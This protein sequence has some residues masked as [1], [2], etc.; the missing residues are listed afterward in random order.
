MTTFP[1]A[2]KLVKGG[3][4]LLDPESGAILRVITLQYNPDT[5]NR[6][7]QIQPFTGGTGGDRIDPKR[8][9]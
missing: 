1:N 6:T 2:P 8:C 9:D 4:V 5:M 3:I 7:L